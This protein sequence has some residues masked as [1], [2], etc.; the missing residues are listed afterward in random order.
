MQGS[1]VCRESMGCGVQLNRIVSRHIWQSIGGVI[2]IRGTIRW[3]CCQD[4]GYFI[5]FRSNSPDRPKNPSLSGK[6]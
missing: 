1:R 5:I 6:I 3:A 2:R 4:F